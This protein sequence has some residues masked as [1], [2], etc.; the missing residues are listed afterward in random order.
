MLRFEIPTYSLTAD[1]ARSEWVRALTDAS[2]DLTHS[3]KRKELPPTSSK[4]S[5][6]KGK[7]GPLD[8]SRRVDI[9]S[10]NWHDT[11]ESDGSN[12]I[13]IKS[14]FIFKEKLRPLN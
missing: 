5:F 14:T 9:Q 12:S 6:Y 1:A 2:A 8:R 3:E 11:R 13:K 4:V 7:I 10:L